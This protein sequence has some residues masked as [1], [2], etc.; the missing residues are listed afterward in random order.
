VDRGE[1]IRFSLK[2]HIADV[3]YCARRT[4][5]RDAVDVWPRAWTY[6]QCVAGKP[7]FHQ[8]CHSSCFPYLKVVLV[9]LR[10]IEGFPHIWRTRIFR[11]FQTHIMFIAIFPCIAHLFCILRKHAYFTTLII[12]GCS[13]YHSYTI[14]MHKL[15]I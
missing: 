13:N 10:L 12:Y 3:Q 2:T 7:Y 6:S 1:K 4:A 9:E 11:S 5:Y 14:N 15:K 8:L